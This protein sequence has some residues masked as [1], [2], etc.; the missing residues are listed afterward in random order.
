MS[1]ANFLLL[2]LVITCALGVISGQH[3]ARKRFIELEVEQDSARK[4]EEEWTQLQLEQSTWGTHKRVEA[5]ASRQLGMKLPDP[6]S[7][8]IVPLEAK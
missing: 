3:Q 5:V 7:T 8:V 4:L 1:K 2:A 6:A